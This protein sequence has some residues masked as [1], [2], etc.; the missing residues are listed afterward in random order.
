M[1]NRPLRLL[2]VL[3]ALIL[4]SC[5]SNNDIELIELESYSKLNVKTI[6]TEILSQ[7]NDY[8]INNGFSPLEKSDTIKLQ[9]KKHTDYMI[10][11]DIVSHDFFNTRK[12]YLN[13]NINAISV[14]ENVAYGYSSAKS[15]VNAWIISNGHRNNI[16]GDFTHFDINAEKNLKGKWYFTNI[17]VKK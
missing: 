4:T 3:C 9:S 7:I 8:R 5:S 12:E 15:V 11:K 17:F 14:A 16:E 10:E 1:N 6:E 2:V 13:K